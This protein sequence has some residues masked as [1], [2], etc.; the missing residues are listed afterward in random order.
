MYVRKLR[1][2]NQIVGKHIEQ[3]GTREDFKILLEIAEYQ[4]SDSRLTLKQLVLSA[5][6]PEST[7]KRR[8]ARLVRLRFVQKKTSAS[9]QRVHCYSL[10]EKTMSSLTELAKTIRGHRWD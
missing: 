1:T 10:P 5:E 8:L 4:E 7:L 2:L 9:D 3:F 6:I